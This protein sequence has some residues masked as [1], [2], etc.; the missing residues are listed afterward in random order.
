M[1]AWTHFAIPIVFFATFALLCVWACFWIIRIGVRYGVNDAIQ[2]NRGL[3]VEREHQD[4]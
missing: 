3:L 1:D 2:M 4:S